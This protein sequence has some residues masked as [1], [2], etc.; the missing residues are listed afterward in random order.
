[1]KMIAGLLLLAVSQDVST[2]LAR[3]RLAGRWSGGGA[4]MRAIGT[5]RCRRSPGAAV[6]FPE[7]GVT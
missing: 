7:A 1:M 3:F 6:R 2:P 5:G 4:G